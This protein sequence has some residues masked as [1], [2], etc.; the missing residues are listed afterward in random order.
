[1]DVEAGIH[2]RGNNTRAIAARWLRGSAIVP[3]WKEQAD[4]VGA[5]KVEV[6]ANNLLEKVSALDGAL[7]DLRMTDLALP[8][9][10]LMVETRGSVLLG[11]WPRKCMRPTVEEI[12]HILWAERI[13]DSL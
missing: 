2:T 9:G 5:A 12:P 7:E 1:M 3:R 13:A 11:Q 4:A 8:N 6:V 10:E